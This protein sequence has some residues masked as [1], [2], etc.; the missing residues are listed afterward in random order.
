MCFSCEMF[1]KV[2]KI[3]YFLEYDENDFEIVIKLE[4]FSFQ[5]RLTTIPIC[6]CSEG[7]RDCRADGPTKVSVECPGRITPM[8]VHGSSL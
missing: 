4:R 8:N 7:N 2:T 1:G 5:N 3:G 6:F